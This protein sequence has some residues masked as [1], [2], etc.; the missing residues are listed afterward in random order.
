MNRILRSHAA[1][2]VTGLF[3]FLIWSTGPSVGQAYAPID[4]LVD[5]VNQL[6]QSQQIL[7]ETVAHDLINS[8]QTIGTM[9]DQGNKAAANQLLTAFTQDVNSLR[10]DLI[11]PSA[12]SQLVDKATQAQ[13][14]L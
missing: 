3:V 4:D 9:V 13:S 7:N 11:T 12:A 2:L 8:L 14:G 6:L 10:G 5:S 1:R